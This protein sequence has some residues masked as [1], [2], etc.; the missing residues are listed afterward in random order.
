[1]SVISPAGTVFTQVCEDR[2]FVEWHQGWP[3]G[4]VWAIWPQAAARQALDGAVHAAR[5]HWREYLLPRYTR[6][7]HVTVAF[8]GLAGGSGARADAYDAAALQRDIA[9]LQ[10]LQM[11]PFAC[12]VQG[13]GSFAMVPYLQVHDPQ[14]QLARLHGLLDARANP[15]H[16]TPHVT[17]GHYAIRCPMARV[18]AHQADW[19]APAPI[20]LPVATLA[21]LRYD[22]RTITGPLALEGAFDLRLQQYLAAP[23]AI[24][25]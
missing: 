18:R 10:A 19:R 3:Y 11:D 20:T 14:G 7:P 6:Q 4:L 12:R 8:A 25:G 13:L 5:I 17:L 2:D 21:L 24:L 23:G 16:Y 15:A 9:A 22:T 1:M